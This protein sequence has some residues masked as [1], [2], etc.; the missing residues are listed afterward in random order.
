MHFHLTRPCKDCPF[1]SD[2]AFYLHPARV[3]A[4]LEAIFQD[5]ETFTCHSAAYGRWHRGLYRPDRNDKHCAGALLL[6]H[7]EDVSHRM[8]QIAELLGLYDPGKLDL[9]A[10]VF[11]TVEA[12]LE[13]FEALE[14]AATLLAWLARVRPRPPQQGDPTDGRPTPDAAL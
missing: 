12:M 8:T 6:I 1:R 14:L 7:R 2:I 4:I 11:P 10:P 13:R 9:S 5:G 3:V